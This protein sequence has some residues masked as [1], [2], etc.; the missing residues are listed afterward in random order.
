MGIG[1]Y[2]DKNEWKLGL[3][4]RWFEN[5]ICRFCN[6]EATIKFWKDENGIITSQCKSCGKQD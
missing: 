2:I 4:A 1:G 3:N 6:K 5:R